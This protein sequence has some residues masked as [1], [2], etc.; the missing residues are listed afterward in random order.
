[1][2]A[3][4][5]CCFSVPPCVRVC[6][7]VYVCVVC[8]HVYKVPLSLSHLTGRHPL[9]GETADML[10]NV[11]GGDLLPRGRGTLVRTSGLGDTLSGGVHAAHGCEV[12]GLKRGAGKSNG[13]GGLRIRTQT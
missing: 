2:C 4:D 12:G 10:L 7:C 8:K 3:H 5:F 9:L 6:V 1:M 13:D 11:L